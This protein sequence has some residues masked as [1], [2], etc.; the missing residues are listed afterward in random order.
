[1][2]VTSYDYIAVGAGSAG[3]ALTSGDRSAIYDLLAGSLAPFGDKPSVQSPRSDR[4]EVV[5]F[6][7]PAQDR[8][9]IRARQCV[10][11]QRGYRVVCG[12]YG[13]EGR[14]CLF[15]RTHVRSLALGTDRVD[16]SKMRAKW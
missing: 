16:S 6:F 13:V 7:V 2:S 8:L 4:Q 12:V 5:Q 3:C 14:N 1:V 9:L 15:Y 10:K 11:R